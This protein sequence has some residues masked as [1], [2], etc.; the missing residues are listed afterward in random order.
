MT[1]K[2]SDIFWLD[3]ISILFKV[4]RLC[5]IIPM[6]N[7]SMPQKLNAI[8]RFSI[9]FSVIHYLLKKNSNILFIPVVVSILTYVFY[10]NNTDN[11][12]NT[13]TKYNTNV[14]EPVE[15][16]TNKNGYSK[17]NIT[18]ESEYNDAN[19]PIDIDID[20]DIDMIEN[21]RDTYDDRDTNCKSPTNNNPFGNVLLGDIGNPKFKETCSSYNNNIVKREQSDIFN[22]D[23]VRNIDDIYNKNNS[24]R[25]FYTMPVTDIINDQTGFANWCYKTPPTCKEGN[26]L[27]C[28]ANL[29][30]PNGLNTSNLL[31]PFT[32]FGGT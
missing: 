3:D 8:L 5:E 30:N 14:S 10:I 29:S 23:L 12:D 11:T 4:N 25:Q 17:G 32:G 26:G 24:Q 19:E 27:Q 16:F 6:N 9:Y 28:S 1:I 2:K 21:I 20:I 7:M 31:T 18:F 15:N 13:Y 22:K